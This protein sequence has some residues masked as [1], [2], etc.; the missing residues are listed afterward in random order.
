M[1][2]RNKPSH[3]HRPSSTDRWCYWMSQSRNWSSSIHL[4]CKQPREMETASS[5]T[6]ILIQHEAACHTERII[7]LPPD[8]IQP[9]RYPHA[10]AQTNLLD[11]QE[12]LLI[13][14]EAWK[15]ASAAHEL[16]CQTMMECITC[17]FSPFKVGNK[18]WLESKHLK[19][20]YK[21]KKIAP[22]QEGPFRIIKV[23]NPLSYRL[24]LPHSW[25]IHPVIHV[26]PPLPYKTNGVY[27][28]NFLKPPDLIK[29]QPE[30]QV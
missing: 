28:E 2:P 7:T 27:G 23:L 24:E 10:F 5:H 21:S 8:G 16:A 4:L 22:K 13:L 25:R 18:V 26:T 11:T 20:R 14:Q 19:L 15:E 9:N 1:P 6:Q 30:L 17:G 3:E 29:G 12:W